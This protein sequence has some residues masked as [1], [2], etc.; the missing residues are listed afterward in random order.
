MGLCELTLFN[1]LN[2]TT[3]IK[4]L[5]Q[6]TKLDFMETTKDTNRVKFLFPIYKESPSHA[7]VLCECLH[8]QKDIEGAEEYDKDFDARVCKQ[9]LLGT[10]KSFHSIL[11]LFHIGVGIS[12]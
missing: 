8:K 5:M 9:I 12:L 7:I 1:F 4:G 2:H 3:E 6:C 10:V 11:D